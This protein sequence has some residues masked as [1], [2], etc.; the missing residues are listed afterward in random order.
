MNGSSAGD[1]VKV[2]LPRARSPI[3]CSAPNVAIVQNPTTQPENVLDDRVPANV[4]TVRVFL[5]RALF[6]RFVYGMRL[7]FGGFTTWMATGAPS[8]TE[9]Y[10]EVEVRRT[11][12]RAVRKQSQWIN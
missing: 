10:L 3:V 2:W 1:A 7:G 12:P 6:P 4:V 8:Q 11:L 5:P 9:Q